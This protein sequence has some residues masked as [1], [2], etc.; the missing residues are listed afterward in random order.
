MHDTHVDADVAP[1][2]LTTSCL[3]AGLPF[4]G[5][6]QLYAR[7]FYA[8]GDT[9]TPARTAA[10]LVVINLC[11]S[12]GLLTTTDMGTAALTLSSSITSLGNAVILSRKF[13][14]HAASAN[15]LTM[16]WVRSLVATGAM[17]AVVPLAQFSSA[18]AP[19]LER[20]LGN[21]LLPIGAG[22]GVYLVAHLLMR[23]PELRL[24]RGV[25]KK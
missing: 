23:S 16:V 18:E 13:R 22:M 8:V 17:C 14:R 25:R 1:T 3:V 12:V 2:V 9:A 19:L 5:L 21:L 15:D 4:L 24:L 6:A 11:I 20:A 7:A 10:K